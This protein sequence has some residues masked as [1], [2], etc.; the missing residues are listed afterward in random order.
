MMDIKNRLRTYISDNF[1]M[2][3]NGGVIGDDTSFLDAGIIDS[4]GVI[5][6]VSYLEE[7]YGI[8]VEDAEMVPENLDSM[9][10][11]ER[12]ILRKTMTRAAAV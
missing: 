4:T 11:I 12:Y 6:L 2:G 3:L 9:A 1:L 7:N 5:E 8:T 10:A